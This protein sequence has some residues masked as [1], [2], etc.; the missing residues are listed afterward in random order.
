MKCVLRNLL[1]LYFR[2]KS[3]DVL[4]AGLKIRPGPKTGTVPKI[5]PRYQNT[6]TLTCKVYLPVIQIPT[7]YSDNRFTVKSVLIHSA[8]ITGLFTRTDEQT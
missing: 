2:S 4:K 1:M 3:P 5:G 7:P 6:G 8:S